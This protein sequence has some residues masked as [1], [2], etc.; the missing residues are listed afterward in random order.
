ML[1]ANALEHESGRVGRSSLCS[2][3]TVKPS[4]TDTRPPLHRLRHRETIGALVG[5]DDNDETAEA[6]Q[7]HSLGIE[8]ALPRG[9]GSRTVSAKVT[10][11]LGLRAGL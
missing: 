5:Y 6:A 8:T 9:A 1:L 10:E 3:G 2:V 7:A 4:A 11:A